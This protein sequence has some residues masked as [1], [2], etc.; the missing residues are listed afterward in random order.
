M[1]Y[2][3]L[4]GNHFDTWEVEEIH[5]GYRTLLKEF[6]TNKTDP[7]IRKIE[8]NILYKNKAIQFIESIKQNDDSIEKFLY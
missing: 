2:I 4:S 8:H 3:Y 7:V 6:K 1:K 5:N